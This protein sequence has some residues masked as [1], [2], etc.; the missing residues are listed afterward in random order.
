VTG[1][2]EKNFIELIFST[3]CLPGYFWIFPLPNGEAN[4]GVGMLSA[5][6]SK[7]KLNIKQIMTESIRTNPTIKERFRECRTDWRYQRLGI[8][9]WI[10]AKKNLRAQFYFVR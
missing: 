4:V 7:R 5:E 2:H 1:F 3:I 9:A 6:I 8:A 10:Q